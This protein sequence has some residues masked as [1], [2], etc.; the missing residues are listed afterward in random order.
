MEHAL[1]VN[2]KIKDIKGGKESQQLHP[3]MAQTLNDLPE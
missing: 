3:Y 2:L 1:G